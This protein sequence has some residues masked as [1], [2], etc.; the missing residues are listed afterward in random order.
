GE[1]ILDSPE[2]AAFQGAERLLRVTPRRVVHRPDAL[3]LRWAMREGGWSPNALL[4]G[5]WDE[6]AARL[7]ATELAKAWRPFRVARIVAESSTVRS[8][9]LEP[10]DGNGIIPHRA[11][12]HLPIRLMPAGS[13]KPLLRTYTLSVAPSDGIYRLSVKR[14]GA[15]SR[16]LHDE[17]K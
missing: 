12:Q 1:V 14:D 8:F 2:I 4:T 13:E 10:A 15:V 11:G 17:V 7:K 6:A 9:H 16:H 5:N 3:P